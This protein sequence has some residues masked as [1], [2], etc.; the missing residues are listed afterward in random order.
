VTWTDNSTG[1]TGFEIQREQQHKNGSWRGTTTLTA[2]ADATSFTDMPGTGTFR[3]RLR[4][5]TDLLESPYTD[6][7]PVSVSGGSGGGNK[8][9][10]K[11]AAI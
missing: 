3:Y 1:E 7:V 4:A 9:N 5:V 8:G 6:W 11:T 2:D 10:K